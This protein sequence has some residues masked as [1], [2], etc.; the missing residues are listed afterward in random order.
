M[1][2]LNILKNFPFYAVLKYEEGL[3]EYHTDIHNVL[4][5]S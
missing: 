3:L 2:S 1:Y 4:H 5:E